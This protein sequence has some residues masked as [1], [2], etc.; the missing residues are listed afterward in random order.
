MSLVSSFSIMIYIG[1]R[2]IVFPKVKSILQRPLN[3]A[4]SH[5]SIIDKI[6]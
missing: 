1:C 2:C 4:K 3:L 6:L 5:G